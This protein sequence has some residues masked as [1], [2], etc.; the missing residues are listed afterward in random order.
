M[1]GIVNK[2]CR[3]IHLQGHSRELRYIVAIRGKLFKAYFNTTL[4]LKLSKFLY[5]AKV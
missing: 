2:G 4:F 5:I 1:F 3:I